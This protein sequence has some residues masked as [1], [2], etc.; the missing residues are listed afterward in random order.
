MI[1]NVDK[2][3]I[4]LKVAMWQ[5]F[6]QISFPCRH[7]KHIRANYKNPGSHPG[8]KEDAGNTSTLLVGMQAGTATLENSM[9]V[10]QK[11]ENTAILGPSNCTTGYLPQRYKCNDL[12]E[13]MHPNVYS[14]NIYNS[15]TME[16][17]SM[18]INR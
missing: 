18:S 3:A 1:R 13:H 9:E 17:A 2:L 4:A 16:K 14:N 6:L 15:Q 7:S 8:V 11:V 5:H 10:P 12:K